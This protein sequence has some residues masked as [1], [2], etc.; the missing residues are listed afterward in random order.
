MKSVIYT[1]RLPQHLI[2]A[3]EYGDL[4]GLN[5][6]DIKNLNTIHKEKHER[7][8][9]EKGK[10]AHWN[11]GDEGYFCHN[12]DFCDLACMVVDADLIILK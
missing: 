8:A 5:E 2:C 6:E 3:I 10:S 12:P 1:Y 9:A 11:Y 4:E 7:L